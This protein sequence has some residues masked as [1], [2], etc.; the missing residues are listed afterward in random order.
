M[1]STIVLCFMLT[2]LSVL[3]INSVAATRVSEQTSLNN[4][5]DASIKAIQL[6]KQY[7]QD[8]YEEVVS[9]LLQLIILQST[10]DGN[11]NI[12]ILEAN[13][14]EGLL[15]VEVS[16]TYIWYGIKK[17]VVSR[18]TVILEEFE[19]PPVDPATVMFIYDDNDGND[20]IW[21][22]DAT[23]E[24]AILKRPKNPKKAGHTFAGWSLTENG[25]VISDDEWQNYLVNTNGTGSIVFYAVFTQN[26]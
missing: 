26:P 18:R 2:I 10:S 19:N 1:A 20:I 24:G 9:D 6:D 5:V 22:E 21:R 14:K 23:F 13:T 7:N 4:V 12:K 16:K 8:N 17:Q 25:S 15:D 11:I 3:T